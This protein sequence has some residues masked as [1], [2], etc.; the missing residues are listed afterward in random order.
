MDNNRER[1]AEQRLFIIDGSSV[2]YRAFHAVPPTFVTSGGL[3]T[4]AVYGFTQSLRKIINDFAPGYIGI[5]FDVKG[6]SFRHEIFEE[7][8]AQRPPMPDLLSVQIPYIKR[9]VEA[10]NIPVLEM[11]SFEADD[12]IATLVR[13]VEGQGVKVALITGDKDMYQLVDENVVILDYNSGKE[14][15]PAQVE[16][17]FGVGP[18][19]IRD[20]IGLAGDSSDNIPGVPGIGLKTAAKLLKEFGDIDAIYENIDRVKGKLRERL[21]ENRDKAMLSR[22]LATLHPEVPVEGSLDSLR[23]SGP[24]F[25][26]LEPLLNELEFRKVLHDMLP[27][28]PRAEA[29][30]EFVR[31]ATQSELDGLAHALKGAGRASVAAFMT[32]AAFGGTLLALSVSIDPAKGYYIPV[33]GPEAGEGGEGLSEAVV[34]EGLKAFLED[35]AKGKDTDNSKAL[36][37]CLATRGVN[38]RGVCVDTSLASYLL[39]PSK[40]DHTLEALEYEYLGVV[41]EAVR[42]DTLTL[43]EATVVAGRKAC[44]INKISRILER[45]LKEEGLYALYEKMELPLSSVLSQMEITGIK[46]DGGLLRDLSK[47]I[48]IELTDI[49]ARIYAAAGTE[50]NIS[51]PKQL[52]ELL[53]EKL[54]LKP[55]K[56]TKTGF[57]TDEEVLTKLAASHEVPQLIITFRQLSKL[58]STY[59]D[60]MLELIN[61]ATGR[62]HTSFNQTV[63]ATGRLSSSRPNL[64]NIPVRGEYAGRIREAFVAEQGFSFLSADYSQIELRL[65]AHMSGD[66]VLMDAF[67]KGEDVHTRT[68]SEVFGIMPGLVTPEMRRRAKAINFGIIYGMGP[69]GLSTELG[70]SMKEANDYIESYFNH[71][72]RVK[73][74]IDAAVEEAAE[75]GYTVTLFGRRRFIPE[76]KSP[77]ESTVRLGRR[78]AINTPVQGTAADM[79]KA[80]MIGISEALR[81]RRL[82]SRMILQIHD[83]LVFE[84]AEEEMD[85]L[86]ALVKAGMEGVITLSV[87]VVVNLKAGRSWDSIEPTGQGG[88]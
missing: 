22:E 10:F 7:Y 39:N 6:P 63:T 34:L 23:Y 15:G 52:S 27:G 30:G 43:D 56:R 76:L 29:K 77:V 71:Y 86:A 13:K 46:V 42:T 80:A 74:F 21:I 26:L 38:A 41:S 81:A 36:Y 62:V 45:L 19:Q 57:S 59:V 1:S 50:F 32:D 35:P 73:E 9:M 17:K 18:G 65:A 72:R 87:P 60:A 78:L 33:R 66:P 54:G 12:V 84:A 44:S 64:Q 51:S 53:F 79:I 55:V 31:V 49:E 47:E 25:Y 82:T 70:I 14:Y 2:I 24:D 69:Y 61:P 67:V 4:N 3:P 28:M 8:K 37:I 40:P 5:A 85:E 48:A 88:G 11:A 83:E 75:R 16:E 68:A 20:L 58:K